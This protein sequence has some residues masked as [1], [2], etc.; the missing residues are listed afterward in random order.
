IRVPVAMVA[1]VVL[2]VTVLPG[3][4]GMSVLMGMSAR[5]APVSLPM[6]VT[7]WP[8]PLVVRVLLVV[9]V[10]VAARVVLR[11]RVRPM[12]R[13]VWAVWAGPLVVRVW[14]LVMVVVAA[15]V[16][17]RARVRSRVRSV[18]AVWGV[19]VARV[20]RVAPVV[21]VVMV[22]LGSRRPGRLGL[23]VAMAVSA[24]P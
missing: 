13:S 15:R 9:L 5:R 22:V 6:V 23:M 18:P 1:P 14:R 4:P 19:T 7:V 12:V 10:V 16:V 3:S 8:G 2:V 20:A 11:A 17:L 24:A 21:M